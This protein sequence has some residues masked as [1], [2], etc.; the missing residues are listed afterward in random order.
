MINQGP[1]ASAVESSVNTGSLRKF[2]VWKEKCK[3]RRHAALE[4]RALSKQ[5]ASEDFLS[6]GIYPVGVFN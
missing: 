3:R 5:G 6:D 4:S 2:S 1:V